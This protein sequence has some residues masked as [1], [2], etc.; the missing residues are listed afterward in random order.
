[1][2]GGVVVDDGLSEYFGLFVGFVVGG[3]GGGLPFRV[4]LLDDDEKGVDCFDVELF[5]FSRLTH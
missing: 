1:M 3:A 2:E 5:L 4:P